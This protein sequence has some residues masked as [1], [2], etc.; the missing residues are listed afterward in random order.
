M[1]SDSTQVCTL[2]SK[3]TIFIYCHCYSLEKLFV[4][5]KITQFWCLA[6]FSIFFQN[7][8][9]STNKMAWNILGSLQTYIPYQYILFSVVQ[10]I[11]VF[12]PLCFAPS[13]TYAAARYCI[14]IKTWL[15]KVI[16]LFLTKMMSQI[17]KFLRLGQEIRILFQ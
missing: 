13:T 6:I 1:K 10:Q 3:L 9:F 11:F 5:K 17:C 12:L 7:Y 14:K 15:S 8:F 2:D 16:F 4:T